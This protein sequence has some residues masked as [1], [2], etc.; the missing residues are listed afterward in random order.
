MFHSPAAALAQHLAR[1]KPDP[2]RF[3]K[4]F[5]FQVRALR[6]PTCKEQFQFAKE[7]FG[8]RWRFDFYFPEYLVAVEIEGLVVRRINGETVVS[9]RHATIT[10]MKGDMEKYNH[11]ALLGITVLRFEQTSIKTG[12]PIAFVQRVLAAKG[13]EG[14]I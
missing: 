3:E 10:G 6:L 8:R 1:P 2:K 11:A 4:D 9:G 14:A 7:A 5:A 13:W 12:E